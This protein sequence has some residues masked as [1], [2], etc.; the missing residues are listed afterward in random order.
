MLIAAKNWWTSNYKIWQKLAEKRPENILA[1]FWR[2][3]LKQFG[4][5]VCAI[6]SF[7]LVFACSMWSIPIRMDRVNL[8]M[9]QSP[10]GASTRRRVLC[11]GTGPGV[12]VTG[13]H[14]FCQITQGAE[15]KLGGAGFVVDWSKR[16]RTFFV[17]RFC[18]KTIIFSPVNCNFLLIH[19]FLTILHRESLTEDQKKLIPVKISISYAIIF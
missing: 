15:K 5:S 17:F 13:I 11:T 2:P 19:F 10:T 1:M 14:Q 8:G 4:N 3:F 12:C 16:G 7:C 18:T 6:R 9:C